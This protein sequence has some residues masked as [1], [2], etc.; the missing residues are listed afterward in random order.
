MREAPISIGHAYAVAASYYLQ[1]AARAKEEG[2]VDQAAYAYAKAVEVSAWARD[3][4]GC[5]D[6]FTAIRNEKD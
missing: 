3:E 4:Y 6:T 1:S 5:S 2:N